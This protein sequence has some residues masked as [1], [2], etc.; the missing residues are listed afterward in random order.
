MA[1]VEPEDAG[2]DAVE[3]GHGE[4]LA[5]DGAV[6]GPVDEM[7]AP[8]EGLGRVGESEADFADAF[9]VHVLVEGEEWRVEG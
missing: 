5:A 9:V 7:V 4:H 1:G 3:V 2:A 8:V 6:A